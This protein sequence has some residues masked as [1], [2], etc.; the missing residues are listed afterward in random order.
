[1]KTKKSVSKIILIALVAVFT[2]CSKYDEGGL[3]GKADERIIGTWKLDQYHRNGADE[4]STLYIS[5]YHEIYYEDGTIAHSYVE[6]DGDNHA[7][8]GKWSFKNDNREIHTSDLSSIGDFSPIHSSVSSSTF[9]IL[10]LDKDDYWYYFENG[11][12]THE[13]RFK[14]Q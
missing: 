5:N 7:D 11:G 9:H 8:T 6:Q 2:G 12:D 1:M 3:V 4:T 10:K 13:F 14:K